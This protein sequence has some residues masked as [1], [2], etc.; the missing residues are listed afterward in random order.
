MAT[1]HQFTIEKP[2]AMGSQLGVNQS[3]ADFAAFRRDLKLELKQGLRVPEANNDAALT[4]KIAWANLKERPDSNAR[5][6][7]SKLS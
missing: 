4:G 3:V 6:A 5:W 2:R 1:K 7:D